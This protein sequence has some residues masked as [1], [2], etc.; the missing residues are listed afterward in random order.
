MHATRRQH[1]N[2]PVHLLRADGSAVTGLVPRSAYGTE[3]CGDES[4]D[5]RVAWAASGVLDGYQQATQAAGLRQPHLKGGYYR[6]DV[7][8]ALIRGRSRRAERR[9][10]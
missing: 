4:H 5:G 2:G 3:R 1:A 8:T 6:D 10:I 9:V 7:P